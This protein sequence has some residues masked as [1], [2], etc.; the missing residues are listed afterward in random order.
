MRLTLDLVVSAPQ[1][2]NPCKDRMISLRGYKIPAIENLGA[3]RDHFDCIDLCDNDLMKVHNL[4]PLKRLKA[5]LL[6]NNRISRIASDAFVPTPSLTSL[7]LTNNK[8]ERLSD[9]YPL[10]IASLS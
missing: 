2:L 5:L 8:I 1:C 9:L 3:T 10:R 6:A 7:V 4:P